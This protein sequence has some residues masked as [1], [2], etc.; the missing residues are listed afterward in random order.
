MRHGFFETISLTDTFDIVCHFYVAEHAYNPR[1]FLQ[2]CAQL[3]RPGGVP[4]FEVPNVETFPSLPFAS[5]LLPYQHIV[6]LTP[7]SLSN[8]LHAAGLQLIELAPASK[9]FGMQVVAAPGPT[10]P[11][12]S[13]ESE[14]RRALN[15]QFAQLKT[16]TRRLRKRVNGAL[17]SLEQSG[18]IVIF[19]AGENGCIILEETAVR[20]STRELFFCDNNPKLQGQTLY[21]SVV[22][23]PTD[24]P[25][26]SPAL[27]ILASLEY[28][29]DMAEQ[30]IELGVDDSK[31]FPAYEGY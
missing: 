13:C 29:A 27:I 11:L 25:R 17:D 4:F 12:H 28:Q 23:P 31:I 8:L 30:L 21:G 3:L 20:E 24:V 7:C 19:C 26:L 22:L 16:N 5:S 10:E 2:R 1:D 9:P 6:H 18:P 14:S 15:S